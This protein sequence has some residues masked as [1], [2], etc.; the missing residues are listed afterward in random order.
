MPVPRA[1]GHELPVN[2]AGMSY[3]FVS[4]DLNL[5]RLLTD[6]VL[7]MYLGK[8]VESGS[9]RDVFDRPAHPY[10]RALMSAVPALD[11]GVR[12][13]CHVAFDG[14]ARGRRVGR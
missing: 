12:A 11:P 8:I 6:R 13:A 10:T 3:L 2:D 7:V 14:E 4:H 1:G 5:V 9:S